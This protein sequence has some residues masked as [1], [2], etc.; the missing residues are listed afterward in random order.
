MDKENSGAEDKTRFLE[1]A[2]LALGFTLADIDTLLALHGE[3]AISCEALRDR[4]YRQKDQLRTKINQ[5]ERISGV[6]DAVIAVCPT[7]EASEVCTIISGIARNA[8]QHTSTGRH[9]ER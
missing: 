7:L 4:A 2:I 6:L 3:T 5:M 8:E 1:E 9:S